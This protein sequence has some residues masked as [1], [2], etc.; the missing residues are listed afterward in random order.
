MLTFAREL[1]E[2]THALEAPRFAGKLPK[3][4]AKL[5]RFWRT[6]CLAG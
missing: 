3:Q 4:L 2:R 5:P 6:A 1:A